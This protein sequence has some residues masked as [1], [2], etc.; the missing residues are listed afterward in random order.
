MRNA[1][2]VIAGLAS[3][4]AFSPA[5]WSQMP[6]DATHCYVGTANVVFASDVAGGGRDLSELHPRQGDAVDSWL[7]RQP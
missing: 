6:F 4:V 5:V 3:F 7:G 2:L 1:T